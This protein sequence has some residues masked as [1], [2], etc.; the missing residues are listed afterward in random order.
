M[1]CNCC[2]SKEFNLLGTLGTTTWLRCVAC[3]VNCVDTF[4]EDSADEDAVTYGEKA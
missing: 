1:V 4:A 2:G 3:G